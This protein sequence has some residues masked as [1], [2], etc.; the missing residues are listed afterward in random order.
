MEISKNI[1]M[2][3]AGL[4]AIGLGIWFGLAADLLI[5]LIILFIGVILFST[6]ALKS[7]G[8]YGQRKKSTP[9]HPR[10]CSCRYACTV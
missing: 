9:S 4:L 7:S 5:G 3:A 1:L 6:S 10:I 8:R 2:I